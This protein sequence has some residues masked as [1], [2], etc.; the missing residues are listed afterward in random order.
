MKRLLV[1]TLLLTACFAPPPKPTP[2][3]R[4]LVHDRKRPQDM[5][6]R[7][8]SDKRIPDTVKRNYAKWIRYAYD[9]EQ[10]IEKR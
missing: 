6:D 5:T 9:L 1:L 7:I 10:E 2:G 8:L 4:K 3:Q